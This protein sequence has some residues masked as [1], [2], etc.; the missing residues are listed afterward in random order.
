MKTI[1]SGAEYN[2]TNK[3]F[4]SSEVADALLSAIV[5]VSEFCVSYTVRHFF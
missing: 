4:D 3:I 1:I 5:D 2:K